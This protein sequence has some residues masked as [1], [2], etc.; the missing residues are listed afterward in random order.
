MA[1]AA[2]TVR[3]FRLGQLNINIEA[4]SDQY[5]LTAAYYAKIKR[6]PSSNEISS[7]YKKA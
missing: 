2:A 4:L 6:R 7:S 3:L 1:D 5:P